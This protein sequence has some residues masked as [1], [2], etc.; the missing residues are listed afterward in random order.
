MDDHFR[1]EAL[2]LGDLI[3]STNLS[4]IPVDVKFG[5]RGDLYI[6]DWYNP[7]KGHM[8]YALRDGRRD[9]TSGRIWRIVPKG[10]VLPPAPRIAGAPVPALLDLLKSPQFRIRDLAKRELAERGRAAVEPALDA[11]V[12]GLD[13]AAPRFRQHQVEALWTYRTIST[14]NTRALLKEVLNC[15]NHHARAAATH[16]TPTT[17]RCQIAIELSYASVRTTT[18][19]SC[20]WKP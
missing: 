2:R 19:P 15:D 7:I 17:S 8:Q 5:P 1:G 11:W 13:R 6:C 3:F 14:E 16:P 4:F 9:R 20:A 10:A 18:M 12:R